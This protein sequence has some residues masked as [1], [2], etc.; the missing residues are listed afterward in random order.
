MINFSIM[1]LPGSADADDLLGYS[2]L[3]GDSIELSFTR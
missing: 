2:V 3:S 1:A